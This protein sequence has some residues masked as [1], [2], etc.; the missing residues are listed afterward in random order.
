MDT[1]AISLLLLFTANCV[2]LIL[3]VISFSVIRRIRGD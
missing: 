1:S 2:F 3:I